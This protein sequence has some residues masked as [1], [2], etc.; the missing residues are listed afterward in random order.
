[1]FLSKKFRLRRYCSQNS[2]V[3]V[4]EERK[5]KNG[6]CPF[7]P[8]PD[9]LK[10]DFPFW[11][12][13]GTPFKPDF[14]IFICGSKTPF[15]KR[16]SW[17]HFAIY[18]NWSKKMKIWPTKKKL[19]SISIIWT[20]LKHFAHETEKWLSGTFCDAQNTH[21]CVFFHFRGN[22]KPLFFS[23]KKGQKNGTEFRHSTIFFTELR[24]P[25]VFTWK[26]L[27]IR[28]FFCRANFWNFGLF[29]FYERKR[30]SCFVFWLAQSTQK[31]GQN[32]FFD[33]R[34]SPLWTVT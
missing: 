17:R 30:E 11:T 13:M 28:T 8:N 1:M 34:S 3:Q 5:W 25:K 26:T 27:I 14:S 15:T 21:F 32:P 6:F 29:P 31:K 19:Y 16:N 24:P 18:S 2:I 33:C 12:V 22:F 20:E 10:P 23:L 9:F 4:G 7:F